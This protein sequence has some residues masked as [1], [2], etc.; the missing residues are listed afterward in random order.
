M[1]TPALT[2]TIAPPEVTSLE[3]RAFLGGMAFLD[4]AANDRLQV[5]DV[6][7]WIEEHVVKTGCMRRPAVLLEPPVRSVALWPGNPPAATERADL[8][9]LVE[10]ARFWVISELQAFVGPTSDDRLLRASIFL[11][12]V[13]REHGHWVAR[14]QATDPLSG[15]AISLFAAAILSDRGR[16]E[17][18]LCV[19]DFCGRVAFDARPSMRS[20]C[21][22]H[23]PRKISGVVASVRS[24][25][26]AHGTR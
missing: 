23:Q 11:G 7:A 1:S 18:E 14:P 6:A 25:D 4:L 24:R 21:P 3:Q 22:L 10:A 8:R 19:C 5:S 15:I 20:S 16:Y 9:R 12:R 26:L 13:R 17:N 2:L